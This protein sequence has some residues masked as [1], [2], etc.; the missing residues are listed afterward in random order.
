MHRVIHSCKRFP[1]T[2]AAQ[3][4]TQAVAH[5]FEP[6]PVDEAICNEPSCYTPDDPYGFPHGRT[7]R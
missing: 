7:R 5:D 3:A 6:G 2:G 4:R 1:V